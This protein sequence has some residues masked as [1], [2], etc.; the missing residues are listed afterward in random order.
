MRKQKEQ[1]KENGQTSLKAYDA[2][3]LVS[4]HQQL[5]TRV[6][7]QTISFQLAAHHHPHPH[8]QHWLLEAELEA[9]QQTGSRK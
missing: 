3:Q 6:S 5:P 4:K 8:S 7:K 1:E 9:P 2:K